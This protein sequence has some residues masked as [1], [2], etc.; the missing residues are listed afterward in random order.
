MI[1]QTGAIIEA[2]KVN[3]FILEVKMIN[4]AILLLNYQ[5][6]ILTIECLHSISKQLTPDIKI[7]IIDNHSSD[8]SA[9]IIS[10]E[11]EKNNWDEWASV[12][13]SKIN[14]GFAYGNNLGIKT[15]QANHYLLLNSDTILLPGA[16]DAFKKAIYEYPAAGAFGCYMQDAD[17]HKS[18]STFNFIT[19]FSE[20]LRTSNFRLFDKFFSKY[21]VPFDIDDNAKDIDWV[22]FACVL[23]PLNVIQNVGLLDEKY[24]M[25][26]DD[27]DYCHRIKNQGYKIIYLP[28]AKIIHLEGGSGQISSK[29]AIT[30]RAP[31]FYYE[32]RSR[33]FAK[34]Y[35]H[36]GLLRANVF[37][38]IGYAFGQM[39][40][41]IG[42]SI[43][44]IRKKEFLDIWINFISPLK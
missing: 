32:S 11:I 5:T 34:H 20:F 33:Y 37:W 12:I 2:L 14:G 42:G 35:G 23:I 43:P 40:K 21:V 24:F 6:P 25:Y 19:P 41:T 17:G 27:V 15:V 7:F 44:T 1:K 13:E 31:R 30:K 28:E 10:H 18:I 22:G 3:H 29:S 8:G 4:I 16:V 36:F 9:E 38:A 39:K 26:F